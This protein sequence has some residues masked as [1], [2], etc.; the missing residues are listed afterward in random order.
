MAPEHLTLDEDTSASLEDCLSDRDRSALLCVQRSSSRDTATLTLSDWRR[1]EDGNATGPGEWH[2][3]TWQV[4]LTRGVDPSG[5]RSQYV[6]IL[7]NHKAIRGNEDGVDI[8]I[9]FAG[10]F[11]K[12]QNG[13][14][15]EFAELEY[16]NPSIFP[17]A[18]GLVVLN[19]PEWN[20]KGGYSL[21]Y[22]EQNVRN[23]S[24][25][26]IKQDG[27]FKG[28]RFFAIRIRIAVENTN[29]KVY[30]SFG[31]HCVV[32]AHSDN[33]D[34][35]DSTSTATWYLKAVTIYR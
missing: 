20:L 23:L 35:D 13:D 33:D 22:A 27:E 24:N 17:F 1:D 2:D 11:S 14:R 15:V 31:F 21:D 18:N 32:G 34:E 8:R 28:R 12:A 16:D 19:I 6:A 3:V 30:V 4:S 9:P 25:I 5:T 29:P 26:T 10:N 7:E